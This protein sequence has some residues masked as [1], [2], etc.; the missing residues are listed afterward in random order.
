[1]TEYK[2]P[3]PMACPETGMGALCGLFSVMELMVKR[4]D[5]A[6]RRGLFGCV[7]Q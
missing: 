2:G 4:S 6:G 1:M 3:A 5:H 7:F